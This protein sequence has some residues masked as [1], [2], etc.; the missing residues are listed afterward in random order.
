MNTKLQFKYIEANTNLTEKV[1]QI[2]LHANNYVH[3]N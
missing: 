1:R 2:I 3:E